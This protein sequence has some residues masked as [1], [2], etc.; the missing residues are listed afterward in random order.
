[1]L[2]SVVQAQVSIVVHTEPESS[3]QQWLSGVASK[4][5]AAIPGALTADLIGK[6]PLIDH[7]HASSAWQRIHVLTFADSASAHRALRVY[8]A[9]ADVVLTE[10]NYSR[11]L[12]LA[13][14]STSNDPALDSLSHFSEIRALEAW[15]VT[16]GR[17]TV[18]VGVI[19]T[20][21]WTTHPDLIGQFA[22][23][24]A[25]DLNGNG[26]LDDADLNGLDEDGN[27]VVDDVMGYD[28]VDR[29]SAVEQGDYRDPDPFA[30][31]D[32][33]L[34]GGRG[35]GTTVAGVIAAAAD[36]SEGIAGVA[37]G[38]RLV[39][40]RAF[41]A[42]GT[43]EDDDIARAIIYAADNGLDVLNLSFGDVYDS[44][45]L[46]EAI[47]YAV[48][49][50][51]IVVASAGNTGGDK[52]HYPSDYPEVLSVAWLTGDQLGSR[53][54]HGI[55]I[56]LGAPGSGIY[57]TVLPIEPLAEEVAWYGRRSGSSVSAPQ[58]AAAAALLRSLEPS[59]TVASVR[60]ILTGTA[61]DIEAAGWDHETGGGRLDILQALTQALPADVRLH[62]PAQGEGVSTDRV[63]ITGTV[64]HPDLQQYALHY[65]RGTE[66]L[67]TA[68]WQSIG[69]ESSL[70]QYAAPLATWEAGNLDDGEYTLR[71]T[72]RLRSGRTLED[73][74]RVIL[75]RTPPA[76]E[77]RA[78]GQALVDGRPGLAVSLRADEDIAVRMSVGVDTNGR[79]YTVEGDRMAREVVLMCCDQA[80]L[81]GAVTIEIEA[82]NRSG[83]PWT[84]KNALVLPDHRPDPSYLTPQSVGLP[85]G[86]LLSHLTDFDNDGLDEVT[87][88]RYQN[89]WVGDTL[90]TYEWDGDAFRLAS[91]LNAN[92]IPR[93]TGDG[94]GD[95]RRELLTQV[96]GATLIVEQPNASSYPTQS[97]FVDTTGLANPF[98]PF[99]VFGAQLVDFDGDGRDELLSHNTTDWRI[100]RDLD[101]TDYQVQQVLENPTMDGAGEVGKNEYQEPEAVV[102]DLD[103]DGDL[104][105]AVGD[106]DGDVIVYHND[107]RGQFAVHWF[108]ES[109]RYQAGSRLAACDLDGDTR[110]EL[111]VFKQEWKTPTQAGEREP[112]LGQYEWWTPA[113]PGTYARAQTILVPGPTSRHATVA[114]TDLDGDGQDELVLVHAPTLAVYA[115]DAD[116]H[117]ALAYIS[118][119]EAAAGARSIA[120]IAGDVDRDGMPELLVGNEADET[121]LYRTKIAVI[122]SPLIVNG[123]AVNASTVSLSWNVTSSDS[124]TVYQATAGGAYQPVITTQATVA[125]FTETEQRTYRIAAWTQGKRSSLSAPLSIQPHDPAILLQTE[126]LDSTSV[127]LRFSEPMPAT[128]TTAA[129]SLANG[130]HPQSVLRGADPQV[131]VVTFK[132]TAGQAGTLTMTGLTDE[133]GTPIPDLTVNILF[134]Q[135]ARPLLLASWDVVAEGQVRLHFGQSIDV[136]SFDELRV[137]VKPTGRLVAV[138][139]VEG[140]Q[141][142]I[143]LTMDGLVIGQPGIESAL[144]LYGL[145]GVDGAVM[146]SEGLAVSLTGAATS[147]A[148]VYPYPNPVHPSQHRDVSIVG[149]P[150]GAT[151][152]VFTA[153]GELLYRNEESTGSS[154]VRWD[155]QSSDG[156]LAPSGMYLIR[157]THAEET[158]LKKLAVI[159]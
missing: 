20:G 47:R 91:A 66:D 31:E 140:D 68:T 81:A 104:D 94:D 151:V 52:P 146:P 92:V 149:V 114:C 108:A 130:Q 128:L 93:D 2:L 51:V 14:A 12:D 32:N 139:L 100:L 115:L 22:I 3:M 118:N 57:T 38:I 26:V 34:G 131:V 63:T 24:S 110:F 33:I 61:Q 113:A 120:V 16:R 119:R 9:R 127:R 48:D 145:Q 122:A 59:L 8:Q 55:G 73:R 83:L 142:A 65:T 132:G 88:N 155:L 5:D 138:D 56:D 64:I 28:F 97:A 50:G 133:S 129:F 156:T 158:V 35:H 75:D 7:T 121:V 77:I 15:Q 13:L 106:A 67:E 71:L 153:L 125:T 74:R 72:A 82:E 62:S 37:P 126:V 148:S 99:A 89:G 54:T 58:V 124:V 134:P 147:L 10:P 105:L 18:R 143:E 6:Q 60:A 154:R 84:H 42:D 76:V 44:R 36:N 39:P 29:F 123:F 159:R 49:R 102:V 112:M 103:G 136:R 80:Q 144:V 137:D 4:A 30:I 98:D 85:A 152:E 41:G 11:R 86:Y 21:V 27:G 116:G 46:R 70:A 117:L 107:G 45:L 141:A 95:G 109:D 1:M 96:A 43:A 53:A 23:N 40:L 111:V 135:R 150:L 17:S 157:V 79:T 69:E 101:D 25:E 19:D 78:L 87:L 90:A